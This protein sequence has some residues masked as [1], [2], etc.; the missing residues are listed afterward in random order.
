V[1]WGPA[2]ALLTLAQELLIEAAADILEDAA[3][4]WEA[5]DSW[6]DLG[7]LTLRKYLGLDRSRGY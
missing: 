3:N 5:L 6:E 7:K 1:I 4:V 2:I